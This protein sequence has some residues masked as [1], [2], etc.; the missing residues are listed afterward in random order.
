MME[1][2]KLVYKVILF[3]LLSVVLLCACGPAEEK[4][5]FPLDKQEV[6]TTFSFT[7]YCEKRYDSIYILHPY[8]NV[9]EGVFAELKMSRSLRGVC[10]ANTNFDYFSTLLF[11]NDGVVEAYSEPR[12]CDAIFSSSLISDSCNAFSFKQEFV[13]D[14]SRRVSLP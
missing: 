4:L 14:E 10:R 8:A 12:V 7:G 3:S 2:C 13:L 6:G 1:D 11:V 9:D 5:V